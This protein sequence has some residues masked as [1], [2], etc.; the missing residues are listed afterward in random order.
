MRPT[1][2]L[3]T[4]LLFDTFSFSQT[5]CDTTGSKIFVSLEHPP[6]LTITEA[7]LELKLNSAISTTSLVDYHAD[8]LYV[9]FYINCMGQDFNYKLAKLSDGLTKQDTISDFQRTLLS[10]FQSFTSWTPGKFTFYK[11]GK[12]VD[13]PVDYQGS[14]TLRVDKSGLHILDEKEKQKHFKNKQKK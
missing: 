2:L 12:P 8:Y 6:R 10:S 7:E 14:Y 13:G 9:T 5:P 11:N 4:F 1:L 3:L